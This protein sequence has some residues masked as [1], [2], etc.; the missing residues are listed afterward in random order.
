MPIIDNNPYYLSKDI[1]I[2]PS[3][4]AVDS[5]KLFTEANGRNININITQSNYVV[6]QGGFDLSYSED[7]TVIIAPGK[8]ILEGFEITTTDRLS[9]PI[10]HDY[11]VDVYYVCLKVLYGSNNNIQGNLVITS[12]DSTEEKQYYC[13]GVTV[14]LTTKTEYDNNK[15]TYLLLGYIKNDPSGGK[16]SII[17]N[18]NK[19]TRISADNVLIDLRGMN[20]GGLAGAVTELLPPNQEISLTTFVNKIMQAY[21]LSKGGDNEYNEIVFRAQPENYDS[22]DFNLTSE[23]TLDDKDYSVKIDMYNNYIY[24]EETNKKGK[25]NNPNGDISKGQ[26]GTVLVKTNTNSDNTKNTAVRPNNILFYEGKEEKFQEVDTTDS[27]NPTIEYRYDSKIEKTKN[28]V[29]RNKLVLTNLGDI[30]GQID[31][32][33]DETK[34]PKLSVISNPGTTQQGSIEKGK[35][36]YATGYPSDDVPS[37]AKVNY[38]L[39]SEG[40]IKSVG[41]ETSSQNN[42][43]TNYVSLDGEN[44]TI[45]ASINSKNAKYPS[46]VFKIR[47]ETTGDVTVSGKV[48]MD[49]TGKIKLGDNVVITSEDKSKGNLQ[50]EGCIVVSQSDTALTTITVPDYAN[51][52]SSRLLKK[53]DIYTDGQCWSAVYNDVAEIF[54]VPAHYNKGVLTGLFLAVNDKNPDEYVLADKNNNCVVGIVSENPA[55]CCGGQDCEN[56]VPVALAGRVKVKYEGK[57]PKIGDY[58]TLSKKTPGY[59]TKTKNRNKAYGKIVKVVD[60]NTVEVI[61]ML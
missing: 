27:N 17:T 1:T 36:V 24:D 35:V 55:F 46:L 40:K 30:G 14:V 34:G 59:A 20:K 39:D 53:G 29:N 19:Y 58:I 5:G 32:K 50:V 42:M 45:E 57:T 18:E 26:G 49:K 54:A 28:S 51:G 60:T 41:T 23:P 9:V 11:D 4:N 2:F 13:G 31:I 7:G 48:Y 3:S 12:N 22:K 6:S 47:S 38:L 37:S 43:S 44:S 10:K 56:G 8:A 33:A 16:D 61:V 15:D 21:Y 52:N 25:E